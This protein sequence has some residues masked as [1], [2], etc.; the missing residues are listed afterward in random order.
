[1]QGQEEAGGVR[2]DL[3]EQAQKATGVLR[4]LRLVIDNYPE[5]SRKD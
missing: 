4:P 3:N 1:M 2:E 5:K